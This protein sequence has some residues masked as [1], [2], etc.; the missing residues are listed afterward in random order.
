LV[1]GDLFWPF[2]RN[3]GGGTVTQWAD[4][5]DQKSNQYWSAFTKQ[6]Q[7]QP[8]HTFWLQLCATAT[9]DQDN[10]DEALAIIAEIRRR[11]PD[12][13]VYISPLN[14][15]AAPHVCSICGPDGPTNMEADTVEVVATGEALEGPQL[16]ALIARC[17][18]RECGVSSAGATIQNNQVETDGCHPDT[19]G[20]LKFGESLERFFG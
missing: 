10:D 11:V 13:V 17:T 19:N 20:Q 6:Q 14:D 12:A 8:A 2:I 5:I 18:S 15:W 7:Q 9:E 3:Y 4:G 16:P 1:G